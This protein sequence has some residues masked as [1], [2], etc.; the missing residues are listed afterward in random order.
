VIR[1]LRDGTLDHVALTRRG[2]A[3]NPETGFVAAVLKAVDWDAVGKSEDAAGEPASPGAT[4]AE[5]PPA[6]EKADPE[7]GELAKAG[8]DPLTRADLAEV[9]ALLRK[10]E[11]RIERLEA[12]PAFADDTLR[13]TRATAGTPAF[14]APGPMP[15]RTAKTTADDRSDSD[16]SAV[17]QAI[18]AG[19]QERARRMFWKGVS[20][21]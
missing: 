4:Q 17:Q 2:R 14:A 5:A 16:S 8:G 1:A 7:S 10:A 18:A 9:M 6:E 21:K 12:Q 20:S 19:D 11:Q 15:L 13:G 3:A